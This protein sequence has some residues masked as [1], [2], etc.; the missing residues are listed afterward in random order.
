MSL[1][2]EDTIPKSTDEPDEK[3]GKDT[4]TWGTNDKDTGRG[5]LCAGKEK[6]LLQ[7]LVAWSLYHSLPAQICK[8]NAFRLFKPLAL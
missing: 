8:T 5:W 7:T 1:Y 2:Q 4:R 3:T 6:M